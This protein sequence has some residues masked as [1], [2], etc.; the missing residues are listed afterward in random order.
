MDYCS[1][2]CKPGTL[3][4]SK[5]KGKILV[6][7]RLEETTSVAQGYEAE[8]AGAVGILVINDE[9][10]GSVLLAE[11]HPIPGASMDATED[12]DIDDREWFGKGGSD[13]NISR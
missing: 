6:C 10:S 7:I 5:V 13:K 3:D 2:F 11:P 1:R 9:K 8:L 12:Q 4:P